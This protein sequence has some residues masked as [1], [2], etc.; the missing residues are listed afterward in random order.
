MQTLRYIRKTILAAALL[1]AASS[2]SDVVEPLIGADGIGSDPAYADRAYYFVFEIDTGKD[3]PQ[4]RATYDDED[5]KSEDATSGDLV[6]GTE[7]EHKIGRSGN[8]AFFFDNDEAHT[9]KAISGLSLATNGHDTD[10]GKDPQIEARYTT[11]LYSNSYDFPKAGWRVLVVLNGQDLYSELTKKFTID[12]STEADVLKHIWKESQ[13]PNQI[14]FTKPDEDGKRLFVMTNSVYNSGD[15]YKDDKNK[16]FPSVPI[17]EDMIHFI[18]D[19][20]EEVPDPN[21]QPDKEI[22]KIRVE[23]MVSKFTVELENL[24][25]ESEYNFTD[26][27][28]KYNPG[29]MVYSP[30]NK[31]ADYADD[32]FLYNDYIELCTG[33]NQ[34]YIYE[35]INV[36]DETNQSET[37]EIV[38]KTEDWEPVVELRK[39]KAEV[40][41]WGMNAL[42]KQSYLYKN[43]KNQPYFGW[44]VHSNPNYDY[45]SYWAEDP[46]YSGEYPW[47]NRMA[48]NRKLNWY[49]NS[50]ENWHNL[51]QNYP[52]NSEQLN[53]T[54]GNGNVKSSVVYTPENTYDLSDENLTN[55]LDGRRDLL[56]GTHLI[57][58]SRLWVD[59]GKKE[60]KYEVHEK[61]YRDRMGV[62][63][64][65]ARD[66]LWG[67]VRV[68][69]HSLLSQTTMKY[70]YYNWSVPYASTEEPKA[71]Y[72]VPTISYDDKAKDAD[73]NFKPYFYKL[74]YN[75]KEMT[76][77]YIMDKN[78]LSD[79]DCEALLADAT[80]K[81]GDGKRILNM[82]KF[83]IEKKGP[84]GDSKLPLYSDYQIGY[85]DEKHVPHDNSK[86]YL[87]E[88]TEQQSV[89]DVQSLLFEWVGAVDYFKDGMMYYHAP[90]MIA[91]E[92]YGAVRNAWYKYTVEGIDN[93]G[94][95][96]HDETQPIVP[97]W[98]DSSNQMSIKIDI[99]DW[100][101]FEFDI[102]VYPDF[103]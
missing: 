96:V 92:V 93:V 79:D 12:N 45:R 67:L 46:D 53:N 54:P 4:T 68:F 17:T 49:D 97:N 48:V 101:K 26:E 58:K 43:I 74:Y 63:Y 71:Y 72:A 73:G 44:N 47:Q 25:D 94:I 8:Y 84:D 39:W 103:R 52:W 27:K 99:L 61:L 42:E 78:N 51:L 32:I 34:E 24:E 1:F 31:H 55:G 10:P 95:P 30:Q 80:I 59:N 15:F 41:G 76:Y 13:D 89:N 83:S 90:I 100:H 5:P 16:I 19:E 85:D 23:R 14:G 35:K 70:R 88:K 65:S 21:L 60:N 57:V 40:L 36:N 3:D 18:Y 11:V 64:T 56:A 69:N 33:W 81:D 9:L 7:D 77:S 66:C 28:G 6:Y 2:C 22:L 37:V 62:C 20:N 82:T 98:D 102:P 91:N 38:I 29:N 50:D 86:Y 75:G 87:S